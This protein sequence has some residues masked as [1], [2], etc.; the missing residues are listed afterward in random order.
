MQINSKDANILVVDDS[1]NN[2]ELLSD[3]LSEDYEVIFA[4]SGTKTLEIV[5]KLLPDLILLD[6]IMPEM[7]GYEVIKVLKNKPETAHIPIIFITAK[8]TTEDMIKGF[9][10]G[11]V[12]Y[13]SK[14]F[15]PEEVKVRVKTQI[16]NQLLFKALKNANRQLEQL[17]RLDPLTCIANRRHFDEFLQQ[18]INRA[19][20]HN[21]PLSLLIIDIDFFK[22]YNDH[23]GHQQGD[24][25]LIEV[26]KQLSK[27]AQRDGELAARYG[28]EEFAIVLSDLLPEE[29]LEHAQ[30]CLQSIKALKIEHAAST[31]NPFVTIS[32]GI[33]TLIVDNETTSELLIKKADAALYK[34]KESGRNQLCIHNDTAQ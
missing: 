33:I 10:I 16:Q 25:C 13:I 8:S 11:A 18:A 20:R 14:P 26:A 22:L 27:Y 31:C 29:A 24:T 17:N 12:D 2:I 28:G 34:A 32:M 19:K 15:A 21:T 3:I 7:D 6:I 30:K 23:Y 4:T 1:I 9:T 5:T